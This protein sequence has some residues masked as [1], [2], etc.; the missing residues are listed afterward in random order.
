MSRS[1]YSDDLDQR[2]L[3][4]W[5]GQVA[6]T[7]RS[8]RGQAFLKELAAAMDAMPVKEL[9]RGE[10]VNEDGDCCTIGVVCK[11]RG[12]DVSEVDYEDPETVGKAV[13]IA[14]QMAAEI[15]WQNDENDRPKFVKRPD[16]GHD[17]FEETP[18]ECWQRMRKWVEANIK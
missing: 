5:R 6:S 10:L 16:G 2:D 4:M 3:A 11:T 15:E 18:A 1:G 14:R 9:I 12:I 13:G 7:I 8:K 17:R